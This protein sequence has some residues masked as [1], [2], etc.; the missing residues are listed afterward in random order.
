M[1]R[2]LDFQRPRRDAVVGGE[3]ERLTDC[4]RLRAGVLAHVWP[5]HSRAGDPCVCGAQFLPRDADRADDDRWL[6]ND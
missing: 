1:V 4:G 3:T 6:V 5:A 2:I